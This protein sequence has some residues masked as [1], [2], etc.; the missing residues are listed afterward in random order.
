VTGSATTVTEVGAERL[1]RGALF[2]EAT[3][4]CPS[5]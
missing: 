2:L 5:T 1:D 3:D 4:C